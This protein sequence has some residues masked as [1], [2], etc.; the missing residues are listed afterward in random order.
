M[1]ELT[2]SQTVG[3][4]FGFA[5]PFPE[6]PIVAPAGELHIVGT[7]YDGASQ[8]VP[9][10]LIEIWQPDATGT[11]PTEPRPDGFR[12]WGRCGT[13]ADGHFGFQT[14]KP[15][16]AEPGSAPHIGVVV[17]ARG[18]LHHL[19]TRIYFPDENAA[20]A[21][22]PVLSR[23]SG[24]RQATLIARPDGDVLRFDIH[25]QGDHETVFFDV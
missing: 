8:P 7:V 12:G 23:V 1:Q 4:F 5:L 19:V 25:L 6:G 10:A 20:N 21:V 22:D 18:I 9:D 14:I 2:P 3:P 17:H 24:E 15:G 11:F 16:P 13:D